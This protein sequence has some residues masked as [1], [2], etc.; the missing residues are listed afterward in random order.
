MAGFLYGDAPNGLLHFIL[1]T[2][3]LGGT[4][5]IASGNAIAGQWKSW[6]ILP[7][8]M[9][10]LSA[11]VRFLHYALFQEELLSF[12]GYVIALAMTLLGAAYGYQS[13]RADQM[14]TQY[15]WLY[16]KAGPFGWR[17]TKR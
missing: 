11:V 4:G 7:F 14:A 3:V 5:A 8:Y 1:L 6:L 2:V 12:Q 10:I 17:L 13:R 15:S 9:A 16:E